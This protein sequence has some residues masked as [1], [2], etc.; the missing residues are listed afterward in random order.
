MAI[1]IIPD[2]TENSYILEDIEKTLLFLIPERTCCEKC[3]LS[4][5]RQGKPTN[6][7]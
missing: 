2:Q 4:N 7:W 1:E 5:R 6:T 3:T